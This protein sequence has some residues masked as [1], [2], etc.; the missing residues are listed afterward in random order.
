MAVIEAADHGRGRK[1]MAHWNEEVE[2]HL[3]ESEDTDEK[4]SWEILF[5]SV[6]EALSDP[7]ARAGH[8]QRTG[9][10]HDDA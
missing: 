5:D 2:D 10:R 8:L 4:E 1:A 9:P 6:E 3:A 7:G